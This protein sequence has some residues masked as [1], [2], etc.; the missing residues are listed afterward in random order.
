MNIQ[1]IQF[2]IVSWAGMCL[3]ITAAL[4]VVYAANELQD[5][6]EIAREEAIQYAQSYAT[7]VA[8]QKVN[9]IQTRL[10]VAR[11]AA[12]ILAQTLRG[13]HDMDIGLEIGRQEANGILRTVLT[14]NPQMAAVY[15]VWEPDAFDGMDMGYANV[16]GHDGTGRFAPYWSRSE[17]GNIAV[18]P[19]QGYHEGQQNIYH[20]VKTARQE[21]LV[22]PH[23]YPIQGE[24]TFVTSLVVPIIVD[25]VFYG[26]TG[27]DLRL[28][29]FQE[30]ADDVK[31][32]YEGEAQ[33]L[34]ISHA[35]MI[36]AATRQPELVGEH[37][38]A[39]HEDWED[40]LDLVQQGR[41][42][43]EKDEDRLAVFTPLRIGNTDKPWSV[44]IRLPYEKVTAAAD[45][46]MQQAIL[47]MWQ[48]IGLSGICAL[49]ALLFLWIMARSISRP[50][51]DA[52]T[53]ADQLAAGNVQAAIRIQ[54]KDEL[55][56]LAG[57]L[58]VM[59]QSIQDVLQE[60]NSVIMAVQDGRL[61]VRGKA[62]RFQGGWQELV[63]GMNSVVEAFVA[64]FHVTTE[65]LD[66]IARGDIPDKITDDAQGD[67]KAIKN[68]VNLL[69]DNIRSVLQETS[70]LIAA[71]QEGNLERRGEARNFVGDWQELVKGINSVLDAF[72]NPFTVTA[73][74]I[75]QVAEGDIPD[76][77]AEEYAGDFT[78]IKNNVNALIEAMQDIT[79]LAEQMADGNLTMT[80]RERSAQDSLMQA[81][82][83]MLHRLNDVVVNVQ[84]AAGNVA[85][86]S[87]G[88][89]NGAES[90][91]QGVNEQAAAAE[92][93][94]SSMEQMVANIR[95]NTDNARQTE[96]IARK[97]AEDA[98][99]SGDAV[100]QTVEAMREIVK[101]IS[102]IEEIARQTHMLSLNA[103]IEA[104]KA[105][106]YGKGFGVVASEVRSLAERA[107]TATEE[108]NQM[109]GESISV[110]ER[111]GEMLVKLVPDIE[112]TSTL[113][114]EITAASQEQESGSE[115]IN[116]AIQQLDTVT[117][118][119]A[120]MTEQIASTAE[121]LANQAE[122]L[123]Q[124]M[125]FF[126]VKGTEAHVEPDKKP[127]GETSQ[128]PSLKVQKSD[129]PGDGDGD[130]NSGRAGKRN[131]ASA[132]LAGSMFDLWQHEPE[133]RDHLDDDFESFEG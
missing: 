107:H 79:A 27:V 3:L 30:L 60:A 92:E 23:L 22:E 46:Q 5:R 115:Q 10:N 125:A 65:Y 31:E 8:K 120:A 50:I 63:L 101:K 42:I 68:N 70:G 18:N 26:M 102:I 124:T 38:Q 55:G 80:V 89:S 25:D 104:A 118:N 113:V 61:D 59:R 77:I 86:G 9:H 75:Y 57:A 37:I 88:M 82:N 13:V 53:F 28:D 111:A 95:Q 71:V 32:L 130:G 64:P 81:L 129:A 72:M 87:Q 47:G 128:K 49:A 74:T 11:D 41:L 110:A 109:A 97:A 90:L 6:A 96:K 69:I 39:A 103:T 132:V 100:A 40:D 114:Q 51:Q 34:V 116:R 29:R 84:T 54:R 126:T 127:Q 14:Q 7:S 17:S 45:K 117:Q 133:T 105:Q 94:S 19:Y 52:V 83:T 2:K 16:Q 98:Q 12:R 62:D 123:R 44:N 1:S 131:G 122:H 15:T 56:K 119:N 24:P 121:E 99:Q 78:V 106:D 91:S 33:I 58:G 93:A 20:N 112:R 73:R 85:E 108:I 48:M 43:T 66:R 35:G 76:Q 36:V 67:F 4:I 21:M